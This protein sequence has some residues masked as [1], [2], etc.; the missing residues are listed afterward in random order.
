MNT[1]KASDTM[2]A[3]RITIDYMDG[4]TKVVGPFW[5]DEIDTRGMLFR[6][7]ERDIASITFVRA[8]PLTYITKQT[9]KESP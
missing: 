7:A 4:R 5:P 6:L 2:P 9:E 8:D 1:S 3:L